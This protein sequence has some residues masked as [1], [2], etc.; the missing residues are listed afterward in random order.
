[1]TN[2]EEIL[3]KYY[4]I[5]D[6]ESDL[7]ELNENYH[8]LVHNEGQAEEKQ[9]TLI[10][11]EDCYGRLLSNLGKPVNH[12]NYQPKSFYEDRDRN[13][14][15]KQLTFQDNNNNKLILTRKM[16]N[17]INGFTVILFNKSFFTS[18]SKIIFLP[19]A[20]YFPKKIK[21]NLICICKIK[22]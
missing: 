5:S 1:M 3:K 15:L 7:L 11:S 17:N 2:Y 4:V 10:E 22:Y 20:E 19:Q 12:N 14:G 13:D 18:Y 8:I 6:D 16:E 21:N 9:F